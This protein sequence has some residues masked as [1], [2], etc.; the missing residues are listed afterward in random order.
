VDQKKLWPSLS[1]LF[2][3]GYRRDL[4]VPVT[5]RKESVFSAVPGTTGIHA[6]RCQQPPGCRMQ[7]IVLHSEPEKQQSWFAP[8]EHEDPVEQ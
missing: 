1:H 7:L 5:P 8:L 3:D 4:A 2:P 6:Y